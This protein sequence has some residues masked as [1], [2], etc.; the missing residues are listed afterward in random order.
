MRNVIITK[1]LTLE[2]NKIIPISKINIILNDSQK[3]HVL[4]INVKSLSKTK[5][6]KGHKQFYQISYALDPNI[7]LLDTN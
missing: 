2:F 6:T 7:L 1:S 4:N 5:E 3:S